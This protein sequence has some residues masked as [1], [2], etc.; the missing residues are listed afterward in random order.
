MLMLAQF[1]KDAD[2]AKDI[3]IGICSIGYTNIALGYNRYIFCCVL[4]FYYGA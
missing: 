4:C 2:K 3:V 1:S